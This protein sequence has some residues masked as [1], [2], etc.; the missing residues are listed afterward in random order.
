MSTLTSI[1]LSKKDITQRGLSESEFLRISSGCSYPDVKIPDK[2]VK[3]ISAVSKMR[4][5]VEASQRAIKGI[6]PGQAPS[7]R[8]QARLDVLGEKHRLLTRI[9]Q[10]LNERFEIIR[11]EVSQ[12]ARQLSTKSRLR[13]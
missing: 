1:A 13:A 12:G 9:E 10:G 4:A 5:K 6:T 11:E 2:L 3:T 7:A 8:H